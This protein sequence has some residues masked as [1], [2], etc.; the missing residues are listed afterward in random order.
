[1]SFW[2][3]HTQNH[4]FQSNAIQSQVKAMVS[5]ADVLQASLTQLHIGVLRNHL[6]KYVTARVA[7]LP[8]Q[9]TFH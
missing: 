3:Y 2:S 1:M 5:K 6:E 8:K 4:Q 7:A 9:W